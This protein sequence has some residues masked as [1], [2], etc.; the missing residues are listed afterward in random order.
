MPGYTR[1]AQHAAYADADAG[2]DAVPVPI[3]MRVRQRR[4]WGCAPFFWGSFQF[5][6]C[7]LMHLHHE[8]KL[9]AEMGHETFAHQKK[10]NS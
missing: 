8:P 10:L 6:K 5:V 4:C 2:D 7:A 9:R 3:L 1:A